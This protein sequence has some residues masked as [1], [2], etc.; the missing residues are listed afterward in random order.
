MSLGRCDV[1]DGKTILVVDDEPDVLETIEEVL[2]ACV[3]ETAGHFDKA[4]EL[5]RTKCYDMVILD[6]MGV[7]G[8]HLLEAAVERNFITVMLTA[9][10]MTPEYLV[11]SMERGASS[12]IPK[13]ELA[14]LDSL[15]S[16]LWGI[17]ESGKSPWDHT[18]KRLE[19]LMC[20]RFGKDWREEH[21]TQLPPGNEP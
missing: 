2:D 19:P 10:A 12:Y 17:I 15:L 11:G 20:E 1:L 4:L 14:D 21:K 8:L 18:L 5:I 9:P 7:K 6:I 16:D 3:V 13:E